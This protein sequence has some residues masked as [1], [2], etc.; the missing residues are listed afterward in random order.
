MVATPTLEIADDRSLHFW[1]WILA[2]C[3]LS[4]SSDN[5]PARGE[6]I[7]KAPFWRMMLVVDHSFHFWG[8]SLLDPGVEG[9]IRT[10]GAIKTKLSKH[11]TLGQ[12]CIKLATVPLWCH[13]VT[14]SRTQTDGISSW[15]HSGFAISVI[16]QIC[17]W[18]QYES[19]TSM[20]CVKQSN[21]EE[22]HHPL[23]A[24]LWAEE[25]N[26]VNV[27]TFGPP[28]AFCFGTRG[29]TTIW[30]QQ[31]R[32]AFW[33]TCLSAITQCGDCKGLEENIVFYPSRE[34]L[35]RLWNASGLW[36]NHTSVLITT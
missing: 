28:A 6:G 5:P 15:A 2:A 35:F 23:A 30:R 27:T 12:P 33:F 20:Q 11:V 3:F 36:L 7:R 29:V 34:F 9:A 25:R 32:A 4:G 8:D 19:W 17:P 18:I 22:P 26:G 14:F 16:C 13:Y 21:R 10:Q 1:A 24:F 31:H